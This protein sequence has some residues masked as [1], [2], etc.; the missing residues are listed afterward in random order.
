MRAPLVGAAMRSGRVSGT[1]GRSTTLRDDSEDRRTTRRKKRPRARESRLLK[2][3]FV[4]LGR[5]RQPPWGLLPETPVRAS[6]R[7][8]MNVSRDLAVWESGTPAGG[9]EQRSSV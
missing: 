9:H 5:W 6:R 4:F 8:F 3:K 7:G 2:R 1:R